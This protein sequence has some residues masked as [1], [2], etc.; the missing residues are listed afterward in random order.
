MMYLSLIQ[1][2]LS[3]EVTAHWWFHPCERYTVG[4]RKGGVLSYNDM[5]HLRKGGGKEVLE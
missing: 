1:L 5:P 3:N 4:T 2:M